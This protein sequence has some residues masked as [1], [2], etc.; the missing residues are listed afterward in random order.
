MPNEAGGG[1]A[2]VEPLEVDLSVTFS[3]IGGL[4]GVV[5]A[6]SPRARRPPPPAAAAAAA[7]RLFDGHRVAA[8]WWQAVKEMVAL[9]LMY[10]DCPRVSY[11]DRRMFHR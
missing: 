8:V 7:W 9:P 10:V 6:R 5:K 1:K 3:D 2:E 11:Q 4:G